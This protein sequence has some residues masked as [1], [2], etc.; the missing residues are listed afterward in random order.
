VP[1]AM[2][3]KLMIFSVM[4][5]SHLLFLRP[6]TLSG[7]NTVFLKNFFAGIEELKTYAGDYSFTR[8]LKNI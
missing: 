8:P 4:P 3:R 2:I 5:A 7:L 1:A 6:N